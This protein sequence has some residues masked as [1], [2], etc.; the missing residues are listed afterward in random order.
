[1]SNKKNYIIIGV[2]VLAIV[3]GYFILDKVFNFE[4]SKES[5]T[6][7][8]TRYI[9]TASV[10]KNRIVVE[11]KGEVYYPGIYEF[12]SDEVLIIDVI[13]MAGGLTN[14]ADTSLI[15]CAEIVT[16]HSCIT[17][18]R[19]GNNSYISAETNEI[20]LININTA[21]LNLL[22]SIP[23][24]GEKK[25]QDIIAYRKTNGFFKKIEDIKMVSGIGDAL[26]E[27]IKDY[28]TV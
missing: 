5:P 16:N 14:R 22:M 8:T 2:I 15:N 23:Y 1:M 12:Y 28:I 6:E 11:I 17:I 21:G 19:K 13:D 4:S 26:F 9:E 25:A 27:K 10:T 18:G 7:V 3:L 20:G 24:I